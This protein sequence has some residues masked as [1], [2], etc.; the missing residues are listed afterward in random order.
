MY[1][2]YVWRA[3]SKGRDE[4]D[5]DLLSD[6][7]AYLDESS[8]YQRPI[9]CRQYEA[10]IDLF[11]RHLLE[12][13]E[14]VL[15]MLRHDLGEEVFW[16]ALSL[17]AE[18]HAR[19]VV[20]TRDFVR[21]VEEASGRNFDAFFDQWVTNAGHPEL[22]VTWEW[23]PERKIGVLHVEQKPTDDKLYILTVGVRFEV[24]G[25]EQDETVEV[26]EKSH[27]FEFRLR[28]KP[29]QVVFDPGDVVLKRLDFK[30]PLP[31]W[32]RQLGHACLGVDRILAA[33]AL[34]EIPEPASVAAL[35]KAL[36]S[37]SFWAVRAAAATALGRTRRDDALSAL[38]EARHQE[39][40][41]VRLAVA[42]ALGEWRNQ[43]PACALLEDWV[44]TGDPSCFV[45]AAAANALGCTRSP[46][47]VAILS[48]ALGRDSYREVIRTR[49]IEGLGA[50]GDEAALP[51]VEAAYKTAPSFLVRRAAAAAAARLAEGTLHVRRIREQAELWLKDN[52]FRVRIEAASAF[53]SFGDLRDLLVLERALAAE[54]DGRTRRHFKQMAQALREKGKPE[55][56]LRGLQEVVKRLSTESVRL[57]ERIEKLEARDRAPGDAPVPPDTA[58]GVKPSARR[59]RP[60]RRRHAAKTSGPRPGPHRR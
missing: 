44:K 7:D 3:Y 16:R 36:T 37:D 25:Q 30:K 60:G 9:L 19:G 48:L 42:T 40:P 10:P 27:T 18:R 14:R 59:P 22:F 38:C 17:Y 8:H 47:A 32:E 41:R 31:L 35:R 57:C 50:T 58:G 45:E 20:E 21:A 13:G 39:N 5:V 1:F 43:E 52:D 51:I 55:E 46:H 29:T 6:G 15:H 2:K 34:G 12:K 24:D 11:D 49:A 23:D 26:R 53:A 54:L 28:K 56:K 33:R 4:A